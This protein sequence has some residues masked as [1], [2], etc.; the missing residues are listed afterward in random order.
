MVDDLTLQKARNL[1]KDVFAEPG[2]DS[3]QGLC[4]FLKGKYESWRSSLSGY[5]ALA[6]SGSY[7]GMHGIASGLNLIKVLVTDCEPPEFIQRFLEH[8]AALLGLSE[9]FHDIDNFFRHQKPTWEK[10]RAAYERFGLNRTD[11]ERDPKAR[12]ALNRIKEIL[13]APSRYDLV[14]EADGLIAKVEKINAAIVATQ[15]AEALARLDAIQTQIAQEVAAAQCDEELNRSSLQLLRGLRDAMEQHAS[16]SQITQAV[17]QAEQVLDK[18]L[19]NVQRFL[20]SRQRKTGRDAAPQA[21][22]RATEIKPAQLAAS[23]YLETQDDIEGFLDNL[24]R[25]LQQA[26][27]RGD[28][29]LIG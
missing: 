28:R 5:K 13:S 22:R 11:L 20:K 14:H 12:A 23:C 18:V 29:V 2:P 24:R 1:G 6:D 27:A 3:E 21:A 16:V 8:R 25:E 19:E 17:Q 26:I 15:R 9:E 7:P 10:L 4:E